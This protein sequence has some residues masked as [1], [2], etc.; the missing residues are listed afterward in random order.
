MRHVQFSGSS[1][2]R[3]S[4]SFRSA[5]TE[6][7]WARIPPWQL[8]TSLRPTLETE[9]RVEYISHLRLTLLCT[10]KIVMTINCAYEVD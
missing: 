7:I 8:S 3:T 1:S 2:T 10:L 4:V 9:N 6:H 5:P